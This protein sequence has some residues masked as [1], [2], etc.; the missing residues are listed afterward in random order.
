MDGPITSGAQPMGLRP[1]HFL[2]NE[3]LNLLQGAA[4]KHIG[5]QR[6]FVIFCKGLQQQK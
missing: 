4:E 6:L 3:E 2:P 1:L 5:G